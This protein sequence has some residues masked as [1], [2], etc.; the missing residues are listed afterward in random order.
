MVTTDT[1]R[2]RIY[3]SFLTDHTTSV[4]AVQKRESMIGAYNIDESVSEELLYFELPSQGQVRIKQ[5]R[6]METRPEGR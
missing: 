3:E 2:Q 1:R 4:L 5:Q 6:L